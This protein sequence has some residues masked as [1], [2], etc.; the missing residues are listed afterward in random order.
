[1]QIVRQIQSLFSRGSKENKR[2]SRLDELQ[3]RLL[4]VNKMRHHLS[5]SI[6]IG[7]VPNDQVHAS[8][9]HQLNVERSLL[10]LEAAVSYGVALNER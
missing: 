2:T 8:A 10:Q 5:N 3:A 9:L 6:R 4:V 7:A 1:M